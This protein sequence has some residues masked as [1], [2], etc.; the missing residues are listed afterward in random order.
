[1]SVAST[2]PT[3]VDTTITTPSTTQH[4]CAPRDKS[5]SASSLP[6]CFAAATTTGRIDSRAPRVKSASS[7]STLPSCFVGPVPGQR[8]QHE[9][10][11]IGIRATNTMDTIPQYRPQ[12]QQRQQH[13][14]QFE[15]GTA[16]TADYGSFIPNETTFDDIWEE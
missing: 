5:A 4:H 16:A 14:Q 3:I 2:P 11:M 1:M 9:G 10:G 12:K 15:H 13:Q 6:I 7:P 8:R